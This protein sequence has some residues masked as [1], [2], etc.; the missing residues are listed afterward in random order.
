[1]TWEEILK[2]YKQSESYK[3][4]EK[5]V[6]KEYKDTTVFP[7]KELVYNA[8]HK[9]PYDNVKVVILGQDPYHDN[10][11]AMGL[12]F[13]VNKGV[14]IPP[15]L[16]NIYKEIS[17][18]FGYDIPTHGDLTGWAEQGVLLLNSILTVRAHEA[19]S[20]RKIGWEEC[21]D[22]ILKAVN[23]KDEPVVYMLWGNFAKSKAK[24]LTNPKHLV[25]QSGHPSP[26][27]VRYFS[28]N[29]HFKQCNEFLEKNGVSPI[30]WTIK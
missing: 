9:T 6:C 10:G 8:L 26:L 18:E 16:M 29:N 22:E 5:R 2:E 7:P 4:L 11:Q 14:K 24:F 21:T 17:V 13:S 19:A 27:S 12:S 28:G 1:M 3:E 23:K 25:L 30:D 15:S 20:H